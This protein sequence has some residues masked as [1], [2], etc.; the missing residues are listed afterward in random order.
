MGDLS[1]AGGSDEKPVHDVTIASPFAVG[2]YEVTFAEWDACVAA[3]GCTHR[4]ADKGWGRGTRPVINVSWDD[5][6]AYVRWLSRE[7]GK[8]YRLL[9][10]A[11]WEYV[12]RAGTT[13]KYWW[14]N[15]ADHAHANY[16]K[17]ELLRGERLPARIAGSTR[18]RWG[19][20]RRM[21]SGCSIRR[22]T[23]GNGWR[24]AGTTVTRGRRMMAASGLGGT[25]IA[26][27]CAAVPGP[28]ARGASA[29][30]T[31]TGTASCATAASPAIRGSNAT[32][33][34]WPGR[35]IKSWFFTALPLVGGL[36]AVP[37]EKIISSVNV[38]V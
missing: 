5:T 28:T 2:K 36:G 15:E 13:T 35:W 1:G 31:A 17:D 24:I 19:V 4:P 21:P 16:G 33:S 26:T 34:V 9:S 20:L 14:G 10:E 22:A 37:P 12:A 32:G 23:C 29:R 7:T 38:R 25:V 11:E 18:P 27:S 6:Q 3:A 30:P 8:P